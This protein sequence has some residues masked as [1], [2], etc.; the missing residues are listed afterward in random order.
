MA[1]YILTKKNAQVWSIDLIVAVIIF[2]LALVF[3][4]K[5]SLN[6][7]YAQEDNNQ[8]LIDDGKKISDYLVSEGYPSSWSSSDVRAIGLTD[9]NMRLDKDKVALFYNLSFADY[10]RAR[11]LMSN[12]NDYYV[13]FEDND[14]SRV[15]IGR[16]HV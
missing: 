3:F 6:N 1:Q 13:Y 16:A 12:I 2:L 9:G 7:I 11:R 5:Y 15:K 4:Y 10:P 8:N 14:M